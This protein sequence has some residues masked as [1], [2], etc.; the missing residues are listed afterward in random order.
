MAGNT[1]IT[2]GGSEVKAGKNL[3]VYPILLAG[4]T[5]TRLWP[6]SRELFPK[7][8]VRF[9]GPMSLI[10]NT[11]ERVTPLAQPDHIRIVCGHEHSDEI[12][13]HMAEI[14]LQSQ[15]KIISEPCGRNTGPAVLLSVLNVLQV[16]KDAVMCI[17]PADHVIQDPEAF[18]SSMVSAVELAQKGH[19]VMFGVKPNYPETGY[20]YIEGDKAVSNGAMTI[21]RFVE[22]PDF[23]TARRYLSA[24]RFFWNSGMFAFR[25]S[26]MAAEFQ[27]YKPRL[28]QKM[29]LFNSRTESPPLQNYRELEN[30]SIDY[31]IM[32]RTEKGVIL[33]VD[34]GWS[35][36][37]S[38]KSLYDYLPKDEN[39]NVLIGD[40]I[41]KDTSGCLIM[42]GGPSGCLQP[43]TQH[44]GG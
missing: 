30:I 12:S 24:G 18:H 34:F 16:E 27:T 5:G 38:W 35:D 19:I 2:R 37:G 23:A 25:A 42:G 11:I 43:D 6:V 14:D 41:T 20:G 10:Q 22:K 1:E 39:Q 40:A 36:I 32:E 17:F 28:Y 29:Q 31:A 33:P 3:P 7:Q 26:V 44:G 15:G 21:K 13:R 8:L 4:G 9:A